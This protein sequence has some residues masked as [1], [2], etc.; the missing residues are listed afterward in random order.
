[1]NV[2]TLFSRAGYKR[3]AR[4]SELER[5]I[6]ELEENRD[7]QRDIMQA[8]K[9]GAAE[10]RRVL[11]EKGKDELA[12]VRREVKK[13]E[14]RIAREDEELQHLIK[15]KESKLQME[16]DRKMIELERA[17]ARAIEAVK[18][19]YQTKVESHLNERLKGLGE[20]Y[21]D[22]LKRLPDINVALKG[23]IS[24]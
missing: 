3:L 8:M 13:L 2:F 12:E 1:M 6:V 24:G 14:D 11:I 23:R 16:Y 7:D 19:E 10:E 21:A 20:M 5:Q 17:Q 22:L 9:D 4:V 18:S 15:M